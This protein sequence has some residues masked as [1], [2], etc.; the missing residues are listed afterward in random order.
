MEEITG[1]TDLG[2]KSTAAD[3]IAG[4]LGTALPLVIGL[5]FLPV[6][7]GGTI[8]GN[9]GRLGAAGAEPTSEEL[10]S[11]LPN[12]NQHSQKQTQRHIPL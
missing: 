11:S 5:R 2:G 10:D 9:S 3:R 6:E 8:L 4:N 1:S 7:P 12:R